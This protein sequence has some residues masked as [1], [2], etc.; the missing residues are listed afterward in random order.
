MADGIEGQGR[1]APDRAAADRR[2]HAPHG[3]PELD[4][5]G[6]STGLR[7]LVRRV[8]RVGPTDATVLIL[9]ERG[10]GKELVARAVHAASARR[11]RPLVAINCAALSPD[12]L[13][14]E[15]FGHERGA[16]TGAAER[17]PGLLSSGACSICR[18][19]IRNGWPRSVSS[20]P[21]AA[22]AT[23]T[24]TRWRRR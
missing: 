6:R 2:R 23:R 12:L 4:L 9:G 16:F 5:V 20:P 1:R 22:P 13:A 24:T 21:W 14:S 3:N 7:E 18:F 15:L 10:T 11:A 19:A 17:R 8:G